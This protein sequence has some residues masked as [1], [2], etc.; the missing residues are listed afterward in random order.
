MATELKLVLRNPQSVLL[1]KTVL[2]LGF[3]AL[4]KIGGFGWLPILFF[5]LATSILFFLPFFQTFSYFVAFGFFLITGLVFLG[6]LPESYFSLGA[7]IFSGLFYLLLGVKS[8]VM[9]DRARAYLL[10]H[11]SIFFL[12]F[13]LFFQSAEEL[14]AFSLLMVFVVSYLLFR[15]FF[16][17]QDF[18]GIGWRQK[19]IFS[20]TLA[21][22]TLQAV[23]AIKILPI[24]FIQS[25]SLSLVLVFIFGNLARAYLSGKL[26]RQA[27]LRDLTFLV[28]SALLIFITSKWSI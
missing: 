28:L 11:L 18:P 23:W 16:K 17:F 12:V 19:N 27:V 8:L 2:F 13:I 3:L 14:N 22:L 5:I 1:L 15:E 24:G 21:F 4:A 6:K 25:A 26:N 9:V 20:W 7:I 10:F